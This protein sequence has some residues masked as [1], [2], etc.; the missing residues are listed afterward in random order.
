MNQEPETKILENYEPTLE[1][2][3][4]VVGGYVEMVYLNGGDQLLVNEEGVIKNLPQNPSATAIAGKP[5][6]GNAIVLKGHARWK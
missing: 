5:I 4:R 1:E 3:Q 2:A 6:V